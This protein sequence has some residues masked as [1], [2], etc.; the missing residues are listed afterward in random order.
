MATPHDR[1][2]LR[3]TGKQIRN[4]LRR[5]TEHFEEDAKLYMEVVAKKPIEDWDLEELA[6]GRPRDKNGRFQGRSPSWIT[7]IVMEEIRRRLLTDT[8]GMMASHLPAAIKMMGDLMAN[9]EVDGNGRPMVDA[10]TKF[11]AASFVIEHF[12][13]KPRAII[14]LNASAEDKTKSALVKTFLLPDGKPKHQVTGGAYV[15]DGNT[16]Q[17]GEIVDDDE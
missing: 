14:D 12:V 17:E 1:S 16:V 13:G 10:K 9:D 5:R 7:P 15:I 8:L 2:K 11:A 3:R 6:R 4:R